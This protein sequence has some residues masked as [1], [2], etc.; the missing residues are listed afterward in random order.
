M[1]K[2]WNCYGERPPGRKPCPFCG[3]PAKPKTPRRVRSV[4]ELKHKR[5]GKK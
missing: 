3:K 2:C 5:P 1:K 4:P